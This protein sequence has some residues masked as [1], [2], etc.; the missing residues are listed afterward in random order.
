MTILFSL[1]LGAVLS[2]AA[3]SSTVR[4]PALSCSSDSIPKPSVFGAQVL[5]ISANVTNNFEGISGNDVCFVTVVLTHPGAGDKVNNWFVLPL[6]GWNGRFQGIGGGGYVA[7]SVP[8]TANATQLGYSAG[9]TDAG[10]VGASSGLVNSWA[11]LSP[12]NVNLELLLNFGRRSL[13]DMTVMGKAVSVS[14]YD[15]PVERAYWNGCSTGGR[16]GMVFAQYY[17][18][19]YDGILADAPAIQWTDFTFAQQWPYTLE[20]Q[21]KFV[22]S[23][24]EEEAV[25]STVIKACDGLDGLIDGI[26]SAPAICNFT[27]ASLAGQ[28]FDCNGT[29]QTWT[30]KL[31]DVVDRIWQGPRTPEGQFLWYGITKGT[32]FSSLAPNTNGSVAAPFEIS[33]SWIRGLIARNLSFDTASVSYAKFAGR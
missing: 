16:Q 2:T 25:V 20:S 6:N 17:P 1:L 9:T 32:N 22:L 14:F 12:G 11:L 30:P 31:V 15:G 21:E 26:I 27:L 7:G 29:T 18:Y 4:K 10:L 33:D 23:P 28:E 13:H 3:A 5:S 8:A 19:D 24:C